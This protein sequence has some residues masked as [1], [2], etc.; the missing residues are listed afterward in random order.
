MHRHMSDTAEM[1]YLDLVRCKTAAFQATQTPDTTSQQSSSDHWGPHGLLSQ[2]GS[3]GGS[4]ENAGRKG[5][6]DP[7]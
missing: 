6:A 5:A 1:N 3:D 2:P 4:V 7:E